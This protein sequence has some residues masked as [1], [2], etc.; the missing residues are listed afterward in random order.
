MELLFPALLFALIYL[1]LIRPQQQ[2]VRA[3]RELI[4]ALEVGD[5]IVTVGGL[6]GRIVALDADVV[7]VE[8]APDVVLRFRRAAISGRLGDGTR[9]ADAS[10]EE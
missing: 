2:R 7:S 4:A 9:T 3:Q 10:Q 5:E 8:A 6:L 1:L